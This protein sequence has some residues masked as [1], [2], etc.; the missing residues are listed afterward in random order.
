MKKKQTHSSF[1]F[2]NI[3][4]ISEISQALKDIENKYPIVFSFLETFCGYNTAL[5]SFEPNKICYSQGK[6]DV[7]LTIKSLMR[8]DVSAENI[9][10]YYKQKGN[11]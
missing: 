8:D 3:N 11:L 9:A 6:R 4:H 2:S 10:N 7:I 5:L 1:E